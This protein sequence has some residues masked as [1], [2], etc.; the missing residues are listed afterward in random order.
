MPVTP[1][2]NRIE[3]PMVEANRIKRASS[4][5]KS[6]DF[7]VERNERIDPGKSRR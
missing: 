3:F 1:G 7:A 5:R 2:R 4:A 6:G